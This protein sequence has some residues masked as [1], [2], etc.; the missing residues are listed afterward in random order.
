MEEMNS[1]FEHPEDGDGSGSPRCTSIQNYYYKL[2]YRPLGVTEFYDLKKDPNT[3]NNIYGS[4][5]QND[6]NN[7]INTMIMELLQWFVLTGDVTPMLM[8]PRGMPPYIPN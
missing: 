3:L 4:S 7:V 2:V 8:D 1:T 5:Q 6:Y